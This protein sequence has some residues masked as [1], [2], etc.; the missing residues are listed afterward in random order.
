M[1]GCTVPIQHQEK[2]RDQEVQLMWARPVVACQVPSCSP[3]WCLAIGRTSRWLCKTMYVIL[4]REKFGGKPPRIPDAQ[5]QTKW[6]STTRMNTRWIK[7]QSIVVS[8]EVTHPS[9]F[10]KVRNLTSNGPAP[11]MSPHCYIAAWPHTKLLIVNLGFTNGHVVD[12]LSDFV[13]GFRFCW[14][15]IGES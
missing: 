5:K 7:Q 1:N 13:S 6:T 2:H 11:A 9:G 15:G 14:M 8:S 10:Q 3:V 12:L 4:F